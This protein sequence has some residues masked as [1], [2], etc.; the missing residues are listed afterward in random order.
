MSWTKEIR[1]F[2]SWNWGWV[3][4]E[5]RPSL[6]Q[7]MTPSLFGTKP[8]SER[9][10]VYYQ[11]DPFALNV[12]RWVLQKVSVLSAASRA[13]QAELKNV[14][15]YGRKST[16]IFISLEP[17]HVPTNMVFMV[18][19]R[20]RWYIGVILLTIFLFPLYKK[21]NNIWIEIDSGNSLVNL[22]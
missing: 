19:A 3:R 10:L 6:V 9:A 12:P 2:Y 5:I 14:Y 11:L 1:W 20:R 16:H 8:L 22:E 21:K 4:Q 18:Q 17:L 7:L 13:T 15:V